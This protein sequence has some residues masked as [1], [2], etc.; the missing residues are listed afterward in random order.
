MTLGLS[1]F[2]CIMVQHGMIIHISQV[3]YVSARHTESSLHLSLSLCNVCSYL[4][5]NYALKTCF[6]PDSALSN[7]DGTKQTKSLPLSS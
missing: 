4:F 3:I 6:I 7:G 2:I 1:F 5:D